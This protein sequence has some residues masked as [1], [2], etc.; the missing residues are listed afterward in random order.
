MRIKCALYTVANPFLCRSCHQRSESS[1]TDESPAFEILDISP[2]EG[3]SKGRSK[4]NK[5]KFFKNLSDDAAVHFVQASADEPCPLQDWRRYTYQ[6]GK[7]VRL[8][9]LQ[10]SFSTAL[11]KHYLSTAR[12]LQEFMVTNQQT[13][14]SAEELEPGDW[15]KIM[16]SSLFEAKEAELSRKSCQEKVARDKKSMDLI[17][18]QTLNRPD[19]EL[20]SSNDESAAGEDIVASNTVSLLPTRS[21][22]TSIRSASPLQ[23]LRPQCLLLR[24]SRR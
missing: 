17:E 9:F 21:A 11:Q 2:D 5:S 1:I 16:L 22:K 23:Y 24:H 12:T 13:N 4:I 6:M 14:L 3:V 19:V 18:E 10:D 7:S 8:S 20:D 15:Q